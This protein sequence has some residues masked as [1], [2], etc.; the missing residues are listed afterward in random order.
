MKRFPELTRA[1]VAI[2]CMA[3]LLACFT[4]AASR[5]KVDVL[6]IGGTTSGTSAAIAAARG[7]AHTLVVEPTPMLG[8]MFTAQGVC[9]AD[10]NFHL[11]SGLWDEFRGHLR[12]RYGGI[13]AIWTGW[14]STTLFEPRVADSVL[15]A[16]ASAEKN[17]DVIHGYR[18]T[19]IK[20][21][22]NRVTGATFID[23]D[24]KVLDVRARIVIDATDLGE[25]LPLS[26]TPY[27]VGFDARN[28]T[29]EL[30]AP[31]QALDVVQDL[32][33]AAILKDYGPD[34]DRT[35]ACPANYFPGE[36]AGCCDHEGGITPQRMLDYARMP[37]GKYMIN[38][39]KAGNDIYLNVV[40]MPYEQR[41]VALQAA[42][43][44]TLR[45]IYYIQHEL[46][47]RN[48][49]IADDE[50]DTPDGLAYLPYHR[51]GR[52]LDGVIR[53][54]LD[55]VSDRYNRPTP[56]YRTGISVGDYPVD[57]HHNCYSTIG[58]IPFPPVPSF[59]IPLG[60]LIPTA[61]DNLIV[62]DKA[63]SVSNLVNG[64]TRL[65]PV[66]ML[67]GQAA[68]TLAAIAIKRGCTPREVPVREVQSALLRQKAYIAPLFDVKPDDADFETLQRIA[69]T[70]I[71]RMTGEP[72]HWDNRSWFYPE[73]TITV[74]EFTQGLNTY[75]PQI[76]ATSDSTP[77][78]AAH[79]AELLLQ[80]GGKALCTEGAAGE[81]L[82]TRR[83][84][85]RMVELA[86]DPFARAIGFDGNY[87]NQLP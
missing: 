16:M 23:N 13:G 25:A 72:Y 78:T 48:L 6:V 51:E 8:G 21:S 28:D 76:A 52:R 71:L 58:Q 31:E 26:G 61:T 27:R 38:W 82:V 33:V 81:H 43:Q 39:P 53:L 50:F 36:F 40:E 42:R 29:G 30:L 10:G 80:A 55:D 34:A 45:F 75:A 17:L 54:T 68:G 49:G 12:A 47:F 44:K 15:K 18:L 37:N 46:G 67:T 62:S 20:K 86:L 41:E 69:A 11:A 64:S 2:L 32:T 14:I 1:L 5:Y 84:L 7:G 19:S 73:Q 66:V 60:A 24:G 65:Q 35:I 3:G 87:T 57:H 74:G 22:G 77:L 79:A 59:S 85:A 83:E 70:G 63:I 4:A 9:A 56:L